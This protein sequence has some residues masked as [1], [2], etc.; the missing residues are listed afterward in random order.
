[1]RYYCASSTSKLSN[2]ISWFFQ[3][4]EGEFFQN[5]LEFDKLNC[6]FSSARV[7]PDSESNIPPSTNQVTFNCQQNFAGP[8]AFG[9][10]SGIDRT[11]E[12]AF[13]IQVGLDGYIIIL[14]PVF[15]VKS[16]RMAV[17]LL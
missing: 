6:G 4:D 15:D 13:A 2:K 1:M 8:N 10:N 7:F 14:H 11:N 12:S 5:D 16:F 3:L 9:S 17:A